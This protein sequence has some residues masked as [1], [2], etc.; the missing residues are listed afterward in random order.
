R[1]RPRAP[2]R[3]PGTCSSRA[4]RG[5]RAWPPARRTPRR[6]RRRRRCSRPHRQRPQSLP[7]FYDRIDDGGGWMRT[8]KHIFFSLLS[9]WIVK[10][11]VGKVAVIAS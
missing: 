4:T 9:L 3:R 7:C 8:A 6:R 10:L 5:W 11:F 2:C 1:R